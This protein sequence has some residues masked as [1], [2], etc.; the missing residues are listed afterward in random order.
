MLRDVQY[1][2]F[3]KRS[4]KDIEFIRTLDPT[5]TLILPKG[6]YFILARQDNASSYSRFFVSAGETKTIPLTLN[7]GTLKLSSNLDLLSDI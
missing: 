5:P 4:D 3:Q 6:D 7:A 2:L 1:T